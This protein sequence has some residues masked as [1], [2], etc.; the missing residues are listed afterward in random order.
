MARDDGEREEI[1]QA[2][3]QQVGTIPVPVCG[4][5]LFAIGFGKGQLSTAANARES[6][7]ESVRLRRRRILAARSFRFTATRSS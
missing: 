6:A 3:L 4:L 7:R 2:R 5:F 1:S